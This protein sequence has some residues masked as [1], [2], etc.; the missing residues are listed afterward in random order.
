MKKE[1]GNFGRAVER[2]IYY[3]ETKYYQV[4]PPFLIYITSETSKRKDNIMSF[5]GGE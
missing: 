3:Y 4:L 1:E 2:K 5:Q